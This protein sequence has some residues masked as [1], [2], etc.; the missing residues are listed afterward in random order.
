[1][2]WQGWPFLIGFM[3]NARETDA[4]SCIGDGGCSQRVFFSEAKQDIKT[5]KEYINKNQ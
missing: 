4:T 2:F 1:M 5:K 3:H